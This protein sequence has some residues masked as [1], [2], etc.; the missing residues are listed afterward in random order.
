MWPKSQLL[1]Y[2]VTFTEEILNGKLF[3]VQWS[4]NFWIAKTLEISI[5]SLRFLLLKCSVWYLTILTHSFPMHPFPIPWKNQKTVRLSNDF[6]GYKKGALGAN[7]LNVRTV[8]YIY[9]YLCTYIC[10]N[11]FDCYI[12]LYIDTVVK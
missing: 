1:A 6:L 3:F 7:G 5:D 4:F 10:E 11:D 2:L 12:N 9:I 8:K